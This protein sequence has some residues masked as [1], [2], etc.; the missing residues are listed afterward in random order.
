MK[1]KKGFTLIELL[2]TIAILAIVLGIASTAY[3]GISKYLKKSYYKTLEESILVSGGEYYSYTKKRPE[4]FGDEERVSLKYLVENKYSTDIADRKGNKCDL[5]DSYVGA[6]KDS[7]DKTNYYV[8]LTCSGDNYEP[9][10]PECL[11]NIG[12][13]LQATATINDTNKVYQVNNWVNQYVKLTFKTLNNVETVYV[14]DNILGT[15]FNCTMTGT[16]IK[17]CSINVDKSGNYEYYGISSSNKETKHGHI[18]I[19]VD[20][21]NP[22][23]DVYEDTTLITSDSITKNITSNSI[24]INNIVKN[25]VDSDSKVQSIRYSFEKQGSSKKYVTIDNNLTEFNIT[26]DLDLGKYELIIEIKDYAGNIGSRT[27]IYQINKN[28]TKPDSSYCNDLTYN[29][30]EQTLTKTPGEGYTF[31]NNKKTYAGSY[32]VTAN[33]NENYVFSDGSTSAKFTCVIKRQSTATTGSCQSVTYNGGEQVIAKGGS[34]VTYGNNLKIDAGT[35]TV[36]INANSNYAFSDNSTSKTLSCT[37]SKKSVAVSWGSTTTFT[38]N[39]GAQGPTAGATS[40]VSGETLNI[41]RTTAT[42]AGSY[43]STASISSVTGGRANKN[44]YTLTENTKAFT[45]NKVTPTIT[46][47]ATSGSVN[48]GSTITF[49]EKASIAGSFSNV[50]GTTSVATISPAIYSSVAANTA[51]TVTITGVSNGSSTITVTFTPTDTTNYNSKTATYTVTGYKVA[52]VGTCQSRIYNGSSQTL[53]SGGTGVNYTNNTRTNYGSQTVIVTL[54]SGYRWSDATTA[55]KTLICSINKK[56]VT[57]TA[58]DQNLNGTN[59]ITKNT[60]Q[61]T[62]SGLISGHSVTSITLTQST[63]SDTTNGTI[64]P[65]GAIIK[66]GKTDVTGNYSITYNKGKL[67]IVTIKYC[68]NFYLNGASKIDGVASN[69]TNVCCSPGSNTSCTIK[70]PTI[71]PATNFD[72]LGWGSSASST[73]IIADATSDISLTSDTNFYAV[74]ESTDDIRKTYSI[75]FQLNGATSYELQGTTYT[76]NE[77]FYCETD[78]VYNGAAIKNSCT[79]TLPTIT[80]SD[81]KV[82]GWSKTEN[83]NG[84]KDYNNG[85]TITVSSNLVL[86]ASTAK[87]VYLYY[88]ANGGTT[89]LSTQEVAIYNTDEYGVVNI[90]DYVHDTSTGTGNMCK[91]G[92]SSGTVFYNKEYEKYDNKVYTSYK[93]LG[94]G[95]TTSSVSYCP[96]DSIPIKENMT[97]YAVWKEIYGSG[98]TTGNVNN[99]KGPGTNFGTTGASIDKG[100]TIVIMESVK[101]DGSGTSNVW[102]LVQYGSQTGYSSGLYINPTTYPPD[103]SCK[104]SEYACTTT[105]TTAAV[106]VAPSEVTLNITNGTGRLT[107]QKVDIDS[108]CGG[109]SSVS[110]GNSNLI[111]ADKDGNITA[112]DGSVA[113]GSKATTTVTYKTVYTC[114]ATVN[115]TVKN[116]DETPPVVNISISGDTYSSGY[117]SGAVATASCTS[118][119]DTIGSLKFT[120]SASQST[121]GTLSSD[122]KS[123]TASLTLNSASSSMKV[124]ATCTTANGISATT[125]A[126]YKIYKYSESS[127]C[128]VSSY[129]YSGTCKCY[130]MATNTPLTTKSCSSSVYSY[131]SCSS[132]CSGAAGLPKATGSCTRTAI[133]KKCYHT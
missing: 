70:S 92:R 1:N 39:G 91:A 67:T 123:A 88:D 6:Y 89:T 37:L 36:T 87:I 127:V 93:Y 114:E 117:K 112:K 4:M 24:S 110:V 101:K 42:N 53:A 95:L 57:I 73:T 98:K 100:K 71:T 85:A 90:P 38:Y 29:G 77:V 25:I 55:N 96:G 59:I 75:E 83:S 118:S 80:R 14:K 12:Y 111:T 23:F 119:T 113:V 26:K 18:N 50:S 122:K 34:N 103:N 109:V 45:I 63:T 69:K 124:T 9:D 2:S 115:V 105:A 84:T 107:S 132:Y 76:Q 86:Y 48:A 65:S 116:I 128:G 104:V 106:T 31:T 22:R 32:E 35:Y 7:Y 94:L 133:Y 61:I 108:Q 62:T 41:T 130:S 56:A 64:T 60:S 28:I 30:F 43:T 40:G 72:V 125:T 19:K 47:S 120:S 126:T 17:T 5:N 79:F 52:S 13:S 10:K 78:K 11:G 16:S 58:K 8:C 49:T 129:S 131:G 51:K 27:I 20:T 15:S 33:L 3:I 99:R 81:G 54:Q 46:L 21:T 74:T 82:Y 68:A 121:A 66:S 44:N 97:L 102:Y